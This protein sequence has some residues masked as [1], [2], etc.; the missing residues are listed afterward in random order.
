MNYLELFETNKKGIKKC[1]DGSFIDRVFDYIIENNID[2]I[3]DNK[4]VK[5][6]AYRVMG[7]GDLG[8]RTN[9]DILEGVL[10]ALFKTKHKPIYT[11]GA[12]VDARSDGSYY[13]NDPN[14][15]FNKLYLYGEKGGME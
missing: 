3:K 11:G 15:D 6:V 1:Q 4:F 13:W 9:R 12:G 8:E 14:R 2:K 10:G 5:D 7:Q